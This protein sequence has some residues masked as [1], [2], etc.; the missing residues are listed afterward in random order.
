MIKVD[1]ENTI[2]DAV[3]TSV[4]GLKQDE[5]LVFESGPEAWISIQPW[6]NWQARDCTFTKLNHSMPA[7]DVTHKTPSPC[8]A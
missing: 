6:L 2:E 1:P 5:M 4:I 8:G 7:L 3:G